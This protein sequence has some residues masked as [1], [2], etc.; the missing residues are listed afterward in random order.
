MSIT[1]LSTSTIN[2]QPYTNE[3]EDKIVSIRIA[4]DEKTF[5]RLV[6]RFANYMAAVREETSAQDDVKRRRDELLVEL[7]SFELALRKHELACLAEERQAEEYEAERLKIDV[8]YGT[9]QGQIE[10]LKTTLEHAQR[11]RERKL[12]YD[13]L[14]QQVNTLPTRDELERSIESLEQDMSLIKAENQ[15][16]DRTMR[17]QK[18]ALDTIV[19]EVANLKFIGK[20]DHNEPSSPS[21]LPMEDEGEV[22]QNAVPPAESVDDDDIE[23]GEVDETVVRSPAKGK[24][25][26]KEDLEEGEASDASSALSDPPDDLP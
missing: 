9:L 22:P 26:L 2:L 21:P 16:Q 11:E 14:A 20:E 15:L 24:K 3:E 8:E 25:K 18:A 12:E 10:Q 6:S 19:K 1:P 5:K 17:S 13:K 4:N 7:D 23:M